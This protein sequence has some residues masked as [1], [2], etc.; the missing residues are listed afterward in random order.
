MGR[1]RS[2]VFWGAE[3]VQY[4]QMGEPFLDPQINPCWW[5]RPLYVRQIVKSMIGYIFTLYAQ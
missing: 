1:M 2:I 5:I 4:A 3:T